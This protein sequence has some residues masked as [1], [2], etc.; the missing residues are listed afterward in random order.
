MWYGNLFPPSFHQKSNTRS[1][2]TVLSLIPIWRRLHT[3]T[4][5]GVTIKIFSTLSHHHHVSILHLTSTHNMLCNINKYSKYIRTLLRFLC[6]LYT[7]L[8][9]IFFK[10]ISVYRRISKVIW[11]AQNSSQP[12]FCALKWTFM[13]LDYRMT[14][15]RK[16]KP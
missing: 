7:S 10:T 4:K 13:S 6:I 5:N 15:S 3:K 14:D 12:T 2:L 16:K 9:K 11:K 8:Y 1:L